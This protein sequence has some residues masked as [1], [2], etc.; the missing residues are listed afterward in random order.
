M[1]APPPLALLNARLI[2]PSAERE[3]AGGVLVVEGAIRAFGPEVTAA[4]IP[5]GARAIDCRGDVVAPGLIDMRAFVGEPG[6]EHRETLASAGRAAAAG[7]VTTLVAMADGA[8]P[9]D[10][11]ATVDFLVRRA[12]DCAAVRALPTATLTKGALGREL[13][14]IGL[15]QAAGAVAFG[16]PR[17]SVADALVMRGALAYA[18]GFDAL[19]TA[20]CAEPGL[21]GAGAMNEGEFSARL[22]LPGVPGAAETIM[23]DRDLRLVDLTG[24]RY[25]AALVSTTASIRAL[26]RARDA[27]LRVSC[28][29]SI[30]NLALNELDVGD[31]RTFLR[32]EPPLRDEEERRDLVAALAAGD[33]D[34]VVSD[35][36]PRDVEAKR[37]PF[38][39]AEPGAVGLETLLA[40][41]LRLVSSGDVPLP[42]LL[43]A[44]TTR[45]AELLGL[46][47]GRLARGAPADLVRFDPHAPFVVD[48]AKLHS[49]CRNTPFDGAR[50]EGVV[51]LTLVAGEVRYG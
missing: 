20:I 34:V 51:R 16:D 9:V 36:D 29:V 38:A 17:R 28:G 37:L 48:P 6:L 33:V 18:R 22:G 15:L 26:N 21:A 19:V 47:Q 8:P 7:G 43:R 35:H 2:D 25:H 3:L 10:D 46:P 30:N 39:E 1:A 49:R 12:R 41:A 42:R 14:E 24:A 50:M 31:Y 13:S 11:P 5:E 23:L 32:L 4:S 40:A 27:G 44:M 45:P